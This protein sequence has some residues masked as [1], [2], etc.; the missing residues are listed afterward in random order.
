M[1]D[2]QDIFTEE[3][4]EF[5]GESILLEEPANTPEMDLSSGPLFGSDPFASVAAKQLALDAVLK[6][7]TRDFRFNEFT[8]ELLLIVMGV[9]KSE[10]G[11]ILEVDHK[12]QVMF[13]RAVVGQSSDQ[14]TKFTVPMGQGL[15]GYVA[16]SLQPLVVANVK[17]NQMHLKAIEKAVGFETRNLVALPVVIRG[18]IFGVL[19]LLNRVGDADYSASDVELLTYLCDVISR[20]IEIRLMINWSQQ[21]TQR[22]KGDAA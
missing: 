9:V 11:S 7:L 6:L 13:F 12:N 22:R 2:E 14:I 4:E 18:Q 21:A 10:A 16:E 20:A 19:E 5:D 15:A 3:Q 8:R 1:R 17:E